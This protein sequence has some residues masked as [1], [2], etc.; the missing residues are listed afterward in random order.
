MI[1]DAV[2]GEGE[3]AVSV[4][5]KIYNGQLSVQV[6]AAYK[7][8]AVT[9]VEGTIYQVNGNLAASEKTIMWSEP[10]NVFIKGAFK[11]KQKNKSSQLYISDIGYITI[12]PDGSVADHIFDPK[13]DPDYS[14]PKVYCT[15]P[16]K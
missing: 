9:T 15:K 14:R 10:V 3:L 1:N 4:V 13:N 8:K 11:L 7:G 16:K 6:K 5:G 2:A 12:Y